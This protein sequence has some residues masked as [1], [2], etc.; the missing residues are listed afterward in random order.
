MNPV[1]AAP[2]CANSVVRRPGQT[3][4]PAIYCSPACRP[5]YRRPA[6]TVDVDRDPTEDFQPGRE[7]IVRLRRGPHAVILRHGLGRFSAT[8]FAAELRSL[9][10]AEIRDATP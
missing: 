5:S 3:G 10:T 8:A 7:W 4:R 2:G 1:C 9:L 6:L